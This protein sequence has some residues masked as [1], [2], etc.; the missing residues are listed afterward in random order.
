M[1][2]LALFDLDGT[3]IST[4]GAGMRAMAMAGAALW[5]SNFNFDGMMAAGSMD[6]LLFAA[7]T[8]RCGVDCSDENERV[9]RARY[10]IVLE[11]ELGRSIREGTAK[12]LPGAV[13][14]LHA[15]RDH[16]QVALGL[17]T[18]N[19]TATAPVKLR[20]VGIDPAMF[21]IA[22]FGDDAPTRPGLVP[23]AM[24]RYAAMYGRRPAPGDVLLIGDT[25]KDVEAAVVNGCL[26][27]GVATGPYSVADLKAAGAT[28]AV[29]N[30]LDPSPFWEL[31]GITAS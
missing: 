25:P 16:G 26:C 14:L 18:G 29:P 21:V 2:K 20:S 28:V 6:P 30:L 9:F 5:G 15:V 19:Y 24:D 22:A 7:A 3:I 8:E 27:L 31:L 10:A 12:I 11:Q 4:Q 17:L 13:D 23:V 1:S